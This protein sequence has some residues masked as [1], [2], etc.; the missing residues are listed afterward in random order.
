ML[1][2]R[3]AGTSPFVCTGT[4][5]KLVHSKRILVH[6]FVVAGTVCKSSADDA[7][8]KIEVI[9]SLVNDARIQTSL[10]PVTCF[11]ALGTGYMFSRA[12]H[13]LHVFSHL[14]LLTCLPAL[15]TCYMFSCTWHWLHVF[16]RLALVTCFP[17]LGSC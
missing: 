2:G 14:A 13:W 3:E 15:G 17:A 9:L 1:R 7:I 8:L 11:P 5:R 12:W 10:A 6:F 4:E 16:P